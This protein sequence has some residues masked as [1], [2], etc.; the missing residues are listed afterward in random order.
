M[1]DSQTVDLRDHLD[2]LIRRRWAFFLTAAVIL[3]ASLA[4]AMLWPP[5]YRATATILIEEQ[6]IPK[7]FVRSAVASSAV[8]RIQTISQQVMT[9]ANLLRI[10]EKYDLYRE[11]RAENRIEKMIAGMRKRIEVETI[12]VKAVDPAS[13]RPG[14]VAIAFTVS[15][16]HRDPEITQR[17]TRELTS[18][19]LQQNAKARTVS[20]E[21]TLRFLTAEADLLSG[22]IAELE[23][24]LADF[25]KRNNT[26][27]P[28]MRELNLRIMEQLERQQASVDSQIRSLRERKYVLEGDLAKI[29]PWSPMISSDGER[30]VDPVAMLR[31]LRA[32]YISVSA[33]YSD[34]HPDVIRLKREI[35]ALEKQV[36]SVDVRQEVAKE[37]ARLRSDLLAAQKKYAEDHPDVLR[38]RQEISALESLPEE[39]LSRDASIGAA[40][41]EADNP[42]YITLRSRLK[43]VDSELTSLQAF[44]AQLDDKL[45]DFRQRIA[46]GPQIEQEYLSLSREY[47]SKMSHYR[48][49]K[50]SQIEASL[51]Q[52]LEEGHAERFSLIDPPQLPEE[53][54]KPNRTLVGLFGLL[55]ALTG[56][57]V[58]AAL[59]EAR[60]PRRR[61][62]YRARLLEA[63]RTIADLRWEMAMLEDRRRHYP[64]GGA[65]GSLSD[66]A[67]GDYPDR[68][69]RA[70]RDPFGARPPDWPRIVREK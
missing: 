48:D 32:Q 54:I 15:F 20:A 70:Y 53:P 27:L 2:V 19:F 31:T 67:S 36:G 65:G 43:A 57:V 37:L 17:V 64:A 35:E 39:R 22:Q 6:A 49:V 5:T 52:D 30:V 69:G 28:E 12:D 41:V 24:R 23:S 56:G 9:R 40:A 68:G 61:L 38:L 46:R 1:T 58:G 21:A 8:Q 42:A 3:A 34:K 62:A 50:E 10:A 25:K 44:R 4:A 60:D 29:S 18:L 66:D 13:G 7:D 14:Q 63:E 11:A 55:L 16:Q 33:R 51:R 47:E 45:A 59:A 26:S